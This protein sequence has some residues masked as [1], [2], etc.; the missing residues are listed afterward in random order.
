MLA[1]RATARPAVTLG[2]TED[3]AETT[4]PL[5]TCGPEGLGAPLQALTCWFCRVFVAG[6]AE[7]R[8]S[9]SRRCD[10]R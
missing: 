8:L 3:G 9:R 5:R 4:E 7:P 1:A 10:S 2:P 6:S